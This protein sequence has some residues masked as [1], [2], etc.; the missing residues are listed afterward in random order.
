[1]YTTGMRCVR[2]VL[3]KSALIPRFAAILS[4]F[5]TDPS[6]AFDRPWSSHAWQ[7]Y[8]QH[9]INSRFPFVL[10]Y[11]TTFVICAT[12]KKDAEEKAATLLRETD[13]KGWRVVLPQVKDWRT[14]V[15]DLRLEK[16][17]SGVG[18]M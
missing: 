15:N 17:F 6:T 2:I 3:G 8:V 18:P 1:M 10:F 13:K 12:D 7:H 14:N 4:A 16:L 5:D 9:Y 11:L